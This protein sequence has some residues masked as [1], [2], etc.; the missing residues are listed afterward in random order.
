MADQPTHRLK[1]FNKDTKKAMTVGAAWARDD[2]SISITLDPF[3]VL[4]NND[5]KLALNLFPVEGKEGM[6]YKKRHKNYDDQEQIP[7]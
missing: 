6:T 7:Y 3:V 4:N 1:A 5:G 2:G